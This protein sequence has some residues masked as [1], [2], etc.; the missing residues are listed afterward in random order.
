M[1]PFPATDMLRREIERYEGLAKHHANESAVHARVAASLS[2]TLDRL[3]RDAK[4]Q[5]GV[6]AARGRVVFDPATG[7][8]E[9]R[10]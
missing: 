4:A 10:P 6:D 2:E 8:G 7:I 9:V 5:A 3:I 1:D